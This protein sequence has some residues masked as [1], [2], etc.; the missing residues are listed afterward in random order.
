MKYLPHQIKFGQVVLEGLKR[1]G[2]WYLAGEPRSGKTATAIWACEHG[3]V[4]NILVLTPKNAIPGWLKFTESSMCSKNYVVTNYEQLGSKKWTYKPTDFDMVII[5]E[6]HRLGKTGKP[7]KRYVTI[8]NFCKNMVHLH[9]SGTPIVEAPTSIYYQM[10]ISRWSPFGCRNFYDFFR[11]WGIPNTLYAAGRNINDYSEAK[12]ELLEYINTWTTYMTQK[13]AGISTTTT[14]ELH[15]IPLPDDIKILYN[16]LMQERYAEVG[17]YLIVCDSVMKLRT[18][19][20]MIEGGGCNVVD[21]NEVQSYIRLH[22]AKIQYM[23]DNFIDK[24]PDARIGIM[25]H[26]IAEREQIQQWLQNNNVDD[27]VE[28]YSSNAHAEG[29]DLSHLDYF[30]IYSQDYSGSKHIQRRDRI[31]NTNGSNTTEIHYLLVKGAISEQVYITCSK[32]LDF[33]NQQFNQE[34]I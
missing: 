31:V 26:F 22:R 8:K 33:N 15:Y 2:Y 29:V 1:H 3:K 14:D 17:H 20:H 25:S 9:L 5:D 32:K 10:H 6:S 27:R 18:T 19:L 11:K 30:I 4:N 23:F 34:L 7:T 21:A 24:Y 28:V 13:D 12:P 16:K